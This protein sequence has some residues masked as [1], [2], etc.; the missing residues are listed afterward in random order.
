[1]VPISTN[2]PTPTGSF[3]SRTPNSTAK[4]GTIKRHA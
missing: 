2:V 3:R 1:M 4:I